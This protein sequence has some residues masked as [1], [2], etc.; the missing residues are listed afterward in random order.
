[1]RRALNLPD[2]HL[3]DTL[4]SFATGK[5][6]GEIQAARAIREATLRAEEESHVKVEATTATSPTERIKPSVHRA[7]SLAMQW[8]CPE[9]RRLYLS[10][11]PA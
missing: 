8:T 11:K 10:A 5:T 6:V 3:T 7:R 9:P 4:E 1:M 2:H